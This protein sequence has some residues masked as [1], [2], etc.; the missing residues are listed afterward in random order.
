M[1]YFSPVVIE[2]ED[3]RLV[4]QHDERVA[5]AEAERLARANPGKTFAVY[6][7]VCAYTVSIPPIRCEQISN[8]TE[9]DIPF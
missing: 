2:R 4:R 3:V 6:L 9:I 5:R 1:N 7:P 8:G